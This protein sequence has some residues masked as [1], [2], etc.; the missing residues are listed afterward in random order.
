MQTFKN[1]KIAESIVGGLSH[2]SKL[3]CYG[4]SLPA[5]S[6]IIGQKMRHVEGS[7]CSIC[8]A[9][10][11]RYLFNNTKNALK[12]REN[13]LWHP[14]WVD[15]MVYLIKDKK[16]FR[17]HDSG[18]LQ[19]VSHLKRIAKVAENTPNTLHWLPTREYWMV[20]EFLKENKK[21]KNLIIRLSAMMIDGPAPEA[22][23][24]RLKVQVSGVSKDAFTCPSSKQNNKCGS[25]RACWDS[26]IFNVS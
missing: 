10:K 19:S 1:K 16:Y 11:K 7:V 6:C 24:K 13:K 12:R 3:P 20:K 2:P 22:M 21:P 14:R 8:Y 15:A 18:E 26:K 5:Q 23:A 17:W 25:C 4:L 9:L